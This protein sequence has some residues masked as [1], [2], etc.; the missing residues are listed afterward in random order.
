MELQAGQPQKKGNKRGPAYAYNVKA[1]RDQEMRVARRRPSRPTST[2]SAT[3][4]RD[5]PGKGVRERLN[6]ARHE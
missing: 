3:G 5:R 1:L 6:P 2:S 4:S